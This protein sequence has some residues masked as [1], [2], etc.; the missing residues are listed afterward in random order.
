M[1]TRRIALTE[2]L[3]S[4]VETFLG[5]LRHQSEPT[6]AVVVNDAPEIA[7]AV[8]VAPR[9]RAWGLEVAPYVSARQYWADMAEPAAQ[10]FADRVRELTTASGGDPQ[11][12]PSWILGEFEREHASIPLGS[13]HRVDSMPQWARF[14]VLPTATDA[15]LGRLKSFIEAAVKQL[16][17]FILPL[18]HESPKQESVLLQELFRVQ[19]IS[20]QCIKGLFD[21]WKYLSSSEY[22]ALEQLSKEESASFLNSWFLFFDPIQLPLD[23]ASGSVLGRVSGSILQAGSRVLRLTRSAS[24]ALD[25]ARSAHF[26]LR[27]LEK[28]EWPLGLWNLRRASYLNDP[29]WATGTAA[30]IRTHGHGSDQEF[31]GRLLAHVAAMR[32][33]YP[34]IFESVI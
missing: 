16:G 28:W 27:L 2:Y 25:E 3:R 24:R 10:V 26:R 34:V 9:G 20:N 33:R 17:L 18:E 32:S 19:A 4:D 23:V 7:I 8:L 22:S 5:S 29:A 14:H 12:L 13:S 31:R 6:I 11:E 21:R 30:L 1:S 15:T